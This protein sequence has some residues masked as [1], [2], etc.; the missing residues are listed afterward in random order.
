M[1]WLAVDVALAVLGL[2]VLAAL[3]WWLWRRVRALGRDVAAA[4]DRLAAALGE[5]ERL[6]PS[7]R[8]RR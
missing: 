5:L 1:V 8:R 7:Q 4:S 6:A 3:G 2:A